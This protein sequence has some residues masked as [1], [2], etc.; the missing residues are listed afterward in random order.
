MG[1]FTGVAAR[2]RE[3]RMGAGSFARGAT[4]GAG[5]PPLR[6]EAPR[7]VPGPGPFRAASLGPGPARA[8]RRMPPLPWPRPSR[9]ARPRH[10]VCAT[11]T[12][13]WRRAR[14]CESRGCRIRVVVLGVRAGWGVGR[15]GRGAGSRE[16]RAREPARDPSPPPSSP[17]GSLVAQPC[18][19]RAGLRRVRRAGSQARRAA[20]AMVGRGAEA[21]AVRVADLGASVGGATR[22]FEAG[23]AQ[24]SR[25]VWSRR[26]GRTLAGP[27]AGRG[28]IGLGALG[29]LAEGGP[30]RLQAARPVCGGGRPGQRSSGPKMRR[31]GGAEARVL[32][33]AGGARR[34]SGPPRASPSA[35]WQAGAGVERLAWRACV[36]PTHCL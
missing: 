16:G 17:P 34:G 26:A 13:P 6:V 20:R 1:G 35:G 3:G 10:R 31:R 5:G 23:F 25:R 22:R 12:P 18:G 29:G 21:A 15:A 14:G 28:M 32:G 33:P 2:G 19:P 30:L 36:L 7:I 8:A 9:A 27:Q 11:P 24:S 4:S